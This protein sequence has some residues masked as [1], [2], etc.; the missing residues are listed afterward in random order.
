[1]P[2]ISFKKILVGGDYQSILATSLAN[3]LG[4]GNG[5]FQTVELYGTEFI[6]GT[7][8]LTGQWLQLPFGTGIA[9]EKPLGLVGR[10]GGIVG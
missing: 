10:W 6:I 3:G 4:N 7:L 5:R 1:M 2:E 9:K 8:N